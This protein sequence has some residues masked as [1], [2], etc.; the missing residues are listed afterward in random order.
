[1]LF[2]TTEHFLR[3]FQISNLS[4]LPPLESFQPAQDVVGNALEKLAGNSEEKS[5]E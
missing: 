4:D 3:V 2:G 5:V 1:M